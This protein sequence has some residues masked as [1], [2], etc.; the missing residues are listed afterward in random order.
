MYK[1]IVPILFSQNDKEVLKCKKKTKKKTNDHFWRGDS[2]LSVH[3]KEISN[4][5]H[6]M[7]LIYQNSKCS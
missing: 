7:I 6:L 3:D 2:L 5:F 1:K 4:S